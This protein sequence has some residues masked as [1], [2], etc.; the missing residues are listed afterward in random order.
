[1]R[2]EWIWHGQV[3]YDEYKDWLKT[4]QMSFLLITLLTTWV[5]CWIIFCRPDW[6]MGR[7]WALR[8]A[9][10]EIARREKAGLPLI[11]PDL[12]P[13]LIS[14]F[15]GIQKRTSYRKFAYRRGTT[16]L[17]SSYLRQQVVG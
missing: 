4:H 16:R 6:P 13:R 11:S 1:M 3:S 15:L 7:E 17:R 8:E 14:V 9:H 10:L 5:T 12:V 2:R